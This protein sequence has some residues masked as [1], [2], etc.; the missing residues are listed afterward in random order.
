MIVLPDTEDRTIVSL[1]VWT[2]HWNVTDRQICHSQMLKIHQQ[3]YS[4]DNGTQTT[5][6]SIPVSHFSDGN[7]IGMGAIIGE[8]LISVP[9]SHFSDGNPI[10]MGE[11][12]GECFIRVPVS[13][14]SDGNHIG[15]GATIGE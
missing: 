2:K 14:F 13:H 15:M 9:I 10:G 4:N 5:S 3:F 11:M 1:F 6:L 12:I 7:P 8:C